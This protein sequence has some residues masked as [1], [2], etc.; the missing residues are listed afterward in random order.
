MNRETAATPKH[1]CYQ[2][3]CFQNEHP[4]QNRSSKELGRAR[5]DV[6]VTGRTLPLHGILLIIKA[7]DLHDA[8]QCISVRLVSMNSAGADEQRARLEPMSNARLTLQRAFII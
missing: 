7:T 6:E 4:T 8:T 1:T 2:V 3:K 5:E